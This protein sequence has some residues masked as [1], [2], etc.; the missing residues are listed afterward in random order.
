MLVL[1]WYKMKACSKEKLFAVA[2]MVILIVG[3][4]LINTI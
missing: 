4:Y 2:G 1:R 3:T